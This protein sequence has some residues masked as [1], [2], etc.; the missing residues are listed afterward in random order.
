[1][2]LIRSVQTETQWMQDLKNLLRI[3]VVVVDL[4][5]CRQ[6]VQVHGCSEL[7]WVNGDVGE[8]NHFFVE[9]SESPPMK[10]KD[11]GFIRYGEKMKLDTNAAELS[12][13]FSSFKNPP[14]DNQSQPT[15]SDKSKWGDNSGGVSNV[16][17]AWCQQDQ[18]NDTECHVK[19]GLIGQQWKQDAGAR[20]PQTV[21]R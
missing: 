5:Q 19:Q 13:K 17:Y 9:L 6:N 3:D 12:R 7:Q 1:M 11:A 4:V 15:Q 8:K 14:N 10:L 21:Q 20:S 18:S 16:D 2:S